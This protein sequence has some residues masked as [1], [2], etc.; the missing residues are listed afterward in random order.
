MERMREAT[1]REVVGRKVVK[2]K[3]YT[4]TYYTL[5]L[6]IYIPK[7]IVHRYG[8]E[9]IVIINTETGEIRAM[10]KALFE[11]KYKKSLDEAK[12]G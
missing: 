11:E 5:P 12:E 9:Y 6:N 1:V 10:P 4:Y 7:H 2:D 3:L 8:K